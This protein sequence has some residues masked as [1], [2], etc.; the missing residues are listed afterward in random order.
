MVVQRSS[1]T[2]ECRRSYIII[3]PKQSFYLDFLQD[4]TVIKN[5]QMDHVPATESGGPNVSKPSSSKKICPGADS[6]NSKNFGHI[7]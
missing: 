7:G 1:A 5:S 3:V 4:F 2:F 6:L